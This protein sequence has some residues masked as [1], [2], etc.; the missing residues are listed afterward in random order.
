MFRRTQLGVHALQFS[1]DFALGYQT[2]LQSGR[3]LASSE[4]RGAPMFPGTGQRRSKK[5]LQPLASRLKTAAH[6]P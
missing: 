6:E 3:R 4:L 5:G 2:D 1:F